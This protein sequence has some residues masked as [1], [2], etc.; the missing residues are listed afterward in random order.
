M[1]WSY[2]EDDE[3]AKQVC[4]AFAV[5]VHDWLL[6]VKLFSSKY[7]FRINIV[8]FMQEE[9]SRETNLWVKKQPMLAKHW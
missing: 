4:V 7:I 8:F 2:D 6:F 1:G 3:R 9:K 5:I